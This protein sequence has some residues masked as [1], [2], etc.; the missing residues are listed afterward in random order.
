MGLGLKA[1]KGG[2]DRKETNSFSVPITAVY[3][4]KEAILNQI[5]ACLFGTYSEQ[6]R[7]VEHFSLLLSY[8]HYSLGDRKKLPEAHRALTLCQRYPRKYARSESVRLAG[9]VCIPSKNKQLGIYWAFRRTMAKPNWRWDTRCR[10]FAINGGMLSPWDPLS[11][12]S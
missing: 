3:I 7:K 10:C 2:G 1:S 4:A 9:A 12:N 8:F 11:A 5:K 6:Q